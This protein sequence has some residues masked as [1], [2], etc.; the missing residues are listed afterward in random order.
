MP[1]IL[2]GDFVTLNSFSEAYN[3]AHVLH[4]DGNYLYLEFGGKSTPSYLRR[5]YFPTNFPIRHDV[6]IK[7]ER[8]K[9]DGNGNVV[10]E[11]VHNV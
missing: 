8:M 1:L 4:N 9:P 6:V 11:T 2:Q 10:W 7:V 5:R 3:E